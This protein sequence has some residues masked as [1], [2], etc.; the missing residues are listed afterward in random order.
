MF[1]HFVSLGLPLLS[2]SLVCGYCVMGVTFC[3]TFLFLPLFNIYI[4]FLH[5]F[6]GRIG[7]LLDDYVACDGL[8]QSCE[9][10]MKREVSDLA[11]EGQLWRIVS[12]SSWL[13]RPF[14]AFKLMATR[15]KVRSAFHLYKADLHVR[16]RWKIYSEF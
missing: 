16:E 4:I 13:W 5:M 15:Y 7:K 10:L 11:N 3:K 12:N 9:F 8:L 14:Q 6:G 1:L 2:C